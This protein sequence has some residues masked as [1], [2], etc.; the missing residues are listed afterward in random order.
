MTPCSVNE[1][2]TLGEDYSGTAV[3]A[4]RL[5]KIDCNHE[6]PLSSKECMLQYL[7]KVAIEFLIVYRTGK[8]GEI[9]RW[10]SRCRIK[11]KITKYSWNSASLYFFC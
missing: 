10:C 8:E 9:R 3:A 2:R 7:G 5:T 6:N 4:K 11:T 1:L